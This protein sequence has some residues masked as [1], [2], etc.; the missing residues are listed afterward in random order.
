MKHSVRLVLLTF[1]MS[2]F[3]NN[4]QISRIFVTIIEC[5]YFMKVKTKQALEKPYKTR[6]ALRCGLKTTRFRKSPFA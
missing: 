2:V 1:D 4:N 6:P 5:I 3:K